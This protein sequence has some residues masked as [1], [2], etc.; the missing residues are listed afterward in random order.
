MT[1]D[2]RLPYHYAAKFLC[3]TNQPGTS[4]RSESVVPGSYRTAVNIHNPHD[5]SARFRM[6]LALGSIISDFVAD[7][8]GPDEMTR[9]DCRRISTEFFN[10]PDDPDFIHGVEG[11]LVIQS[12]HSLDVT[13]VYSAAE[14][15]GSVQSIDVEQIS[16]RI[17]TD[18]PDGLCVGEFSVDFTV[19]AP[20][21]RPNPLVSGGFTFE[22]QAPNQPHTTIEQMAGQTGLDCGN[23]LAVGIDPPASSVELVLVHHAVPAVIV[24]TSGGSNVGPAVTMGAA[25]GVPETVTFV[26]ADIDTVVIRSPEN[27]VLLLCFG[28]D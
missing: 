15:G 10:K 13:A 16:E 11:F 6:K 4:A 8:L 21:P 20:G 18:G 28:A 24:A 19:E 2:P 27:E 17:F 9:V 1:H 23:A 7:G 25:V 26:G 12:S 22:L 14:L 5:D 3:I